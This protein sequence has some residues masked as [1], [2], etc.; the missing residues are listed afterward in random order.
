MSNYYKNRRSIEIKVGLFVIA[1][2]VILFLGIVFLKDI[3]Y[4]G[5]REE[6]T[7]KFPSTDGLDPGDKVKLN[8]IAIGKITD[9]TLVQDG[10]L[11]QVI[12]QVPDFSFA[13]DTYFVASESSL[14]GGHHLEIIPGISDK[15]LDFNKLQVGK[16]GSSIYAMIDE[17]KTLIVDL[18]TVINN[19][20]ANLDIIDST[21]TLIY[22]SDQAVN[23]L[24][25][26]ILDNK[27]GIEAIVSNLQNS[28]STLNS[29]LND[30]KS[31]IDTVLTNIPQ[32]IDNLD[33]NLAELKEFLSKL[34]IL[35][36]EYNQSDST[37]KKLLEE[38]GLY[39]KLNKTIDEADSLLKDIK[40]NPKKY[41]DLKIF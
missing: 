4:A 21:K 6:L 16:Q 31:N 37:V 15:E 26:L 14:M 3:Y 22:N 27:Q 28:T 25:S 20:N 38:K 5:N 23:N 1:G 33:N 35:F 36:D 8:G 30:N 10:V 13:E 2:I 29:L 18:K 7:I 17:A 41:I 39:E 34:N 12:I 32:T 9:I 40:K 24:N 19:V 11:V